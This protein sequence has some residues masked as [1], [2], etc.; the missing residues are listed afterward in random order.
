LVRSLAEP[1]EPVPLRL[2]TRCLGNL[3]PLHRLH[4]GEP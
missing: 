3:L 1:V 2:N 4:E